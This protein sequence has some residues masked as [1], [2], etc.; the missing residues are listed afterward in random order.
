VS[1][2]II[3]LESAAYR[4]QAEITLGGGRLRRHHPSGSY[5]FVIVL[6]S[7][8]D[9]GANLGFWI[10]QE[11]SAIHYYYASGL[12]SDST[13]PRIQGRSISVLRFGERWCFF[14]RSPPALLRTLSAPLAGTTVPGS[15][16]FMPAL[17]G[18][19][20]DESLLLIAYYLGREPENSHA[21][22]H[23][24]RVCRRYRAAIIF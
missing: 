1:A 6:H 14:R 23:R 13:N 21:P 4:Y 3:A 11:R 12:F 5:G 18:R 8:N 9:R 2:I 7:G 10:G 24:L 17:Q 19:R 16:F 20:V 22:S 15:A